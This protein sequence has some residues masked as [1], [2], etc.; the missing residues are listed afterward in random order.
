[1][2]KR[3]VLF[4]AAATL[5]AGAGNLY[6]QCEGHSHGTES[7]SHGCSSSSEGKSCCSSKKAKS[8]TTTD[9]PSI[10]MK[11]ISLDELRNVI[12]AHNPTIL[13]ARDEQSYNAGHINGAVLYTSNQLP[14]NK[15]TPLV[16]YCGGMKCPASSKAAK[17][18]IEQ[19]Y[20]NVMVFKGGWA[21]WSKSQ[22]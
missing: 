17:K 8:A 4:A 1:M 16:F 5:F 10:S 18:A 2:L 3:F 22:I 13:D 9:S 19:G 20:T 14:A 21:E 7:A 11:E 12:S 6:A 15:N